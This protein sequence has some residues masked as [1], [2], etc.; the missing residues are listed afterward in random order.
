MCNTN[1]L[2]KFKVI[3]AACENMG[4][5]I[6][7]D[8]P[9]RLKNEMAY[10]TKMTSTTKGTNKKNAVI[11]GR[12]T[13]ESIPLKYKPLSDRFNVVISNTLEDTGYENVPVYKSLDQAMEAIRES[14]YSETIEDIWIIGG[15]RLYE[16]AINSPLCDKIYLTRVKGKFECDTFFPNIPPHYKEIQEEGVPKEL[17]EE[18]GISYMYTVLVQ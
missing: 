4:I 12:K 10:F 8:I 17:Q 1:K 11:M 3:A 5:G 7:G 14:P 18:K 6:K 2:L 13:W 16:E 15:S 9:W